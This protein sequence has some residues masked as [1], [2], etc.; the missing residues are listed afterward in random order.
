MAT[1]SDE[2]QMLTCMFQPSSSCR[3]FAMANM[4]TPLTST[5]MTANEMPASERA[6]FAVA[7]LQVAGHGVRLADVVERHHHDGQEQDG[8]NG[9][10][11]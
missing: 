1:V 5:V 9:A 3:I 8:G 10:D 4:L 7:Q 6:P 2:T 11:K